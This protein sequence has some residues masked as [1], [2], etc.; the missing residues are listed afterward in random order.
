MAWRKSNA[1]LVGSLRTYR[2]LKMMGWEL[3]YFELGWRLRYKTYVVSDNRTGFN[4]CH[5]SVFLLK[6][7][8]ILRR[9]D[10]CQARIDIAFLLT[11]EELRIAKT[12]PH[13]NF[14][15]SQVKGENIRDSICP[16]RSWIL[17]AHDR[18]SYLPSL[19]PLSK[20]PPGGTSVKTNLIFH[21]I[22]WTLL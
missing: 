16:M 10:T 19:T 6:S 12:F 11:S 9:Y 14:R 3:L 15:H 17:W 5:K 7:N 20:P 18:I 8:S 1:K 22:S 21:E 2:G 4:T 13:I